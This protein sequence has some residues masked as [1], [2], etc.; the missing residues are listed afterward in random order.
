MASPNIVIG[1]E[2]VNGDLVSEKLHQDIAFLANRIER[3][4]RQPSPN[5]QVIKVY[6][7]MLDS[8][9]AVLDWLNR[10]QRVG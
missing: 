9:N 4:N 2:L 5:P 8:R 10:E 3:L 1:N 6:Q 7:D